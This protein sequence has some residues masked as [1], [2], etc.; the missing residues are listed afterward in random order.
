MTRHSIDWHTKQDEDYLQLCI[1]RLSQPPLFWVE[2]FVTFINQKT[3]DW[4]DAPRKVNDIGCCT[5]AFN[6][7]LRELGQCPI[8]YQGYDISQTYL[9]IARLHFPKRPFELLDIGQGKPR[10][11]D[12]SVMS[13]TLEH[14][15][16]WQ[17]ALTHICQTT[18]RFVLMRTFLG[19]SFE[20]GHYSQPG[21]NHSYP[22]Y[23][24]TFQQLHEE[25]E[26][27][28]FS[29]E[30]MRDKATDSIPKYLGCGITRTQ[31]VCLLTAKGA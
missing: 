10:E 9:D 22:I 28:G 7:G 2:Q 8:D 30:M 6:V 31:Y 12:I 23:Q 1:D 4:G 5:G 20:V 13:G 15:D 24:F 25:A 29:V 19:T 14:V 17:S 27:H 16:E 18:K 21:A 26:K 3:V 11:T